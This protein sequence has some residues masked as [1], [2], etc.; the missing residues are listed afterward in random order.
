MGDVK[1]SSDVRKE[2]CK[3]IQRRILANYS[4]VFTAG[5]RVIHTL[6]NSPETAASARWK[7]NGSH[8]G[9]DCQLP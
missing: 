8:H 7:R 2:S 3:R 6:V 1:R 5:Q 9:L 4:D